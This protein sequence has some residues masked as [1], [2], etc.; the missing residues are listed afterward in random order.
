MSHKKYWRISDRGR[1]LVATGFISDDPADAPPMPEGLTRSELLAL[2]ELLEGGA[3]LEG[4]DADKLLRK[5]LRL[6][7][8][9]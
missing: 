9:A 8:T 7:G 5:L 4:L 3:Y 2:A 6:A 1:A